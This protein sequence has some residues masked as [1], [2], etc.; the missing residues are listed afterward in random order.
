MV[1]N[2]ENR[3]FSAIS[4]ISDASSQSSRA[5][6]FICCSNSDKKYL[7]KLKTFLK[8]YRRKDTLNIWDNLSMQPGLV[9]EQEIEQALQSAKVAVLL[10]SND[11]F[12]NDT[13]IEH[14]LPQ[15]ITAGLNKNITIINVILRPC[16][17]G[18]TEL[19]QFHPANDPTRP[20]INMRPAEQEECW[21]TTAKSIRDRVAEQTGTTFERLFGQPETLTT[22]AHLFF[23]CRYMQNKN[24]RE[25]VLGRL[26]TEMIQE[27][28]A[29]RNTTQDG[30]SI[31]FKE[32]LNLVKICSS[33]P[34]GLEKLAYALYQSERASQAWKELDKY[35]CKSGKKLVTYT[36]WQELYEILKP[37]QWPDHLLRRAYR[38]SVPENWEILHD[39]DVHDKIQPILEDLTRIPF[40]NNG[41]FPILEFVLRLA[42]IAEDRQEG[43]LHDTLITWHLERCGDLGLTE[44]Q[45]KALHE[46]ASQRQQPSPLYL[47][48]M[49]D[50]IS[51]TTF[52]VR[53]WLLDEKNI[54]IQNTA[55]EIPDEPYLLEEIPDLFED[56]LERC[57]NHLLDD[58]ENLVIE[59]VLPL[60]LLSYPVDQY[61]IR[62]LTNLQSIGLNH[63]VV[64]RSL[65]RMR[66][67]KRQT[68][69]INK[70][71]LLLD[72]MKDE[73]ALSKNNS[74]TF[75]Y[76]E[77]SY[78]GQEAF[79]ALLQ[80]SSIACLVLPC[81]PST[82]SSQ[83]NGVLTA[84]LEAGVPIALW[85]RE[86]T[87][88]PEA[89]H[90]WLT[91]LV[92][93]HPLSQLPAL[94]KQQRHEAIAS[95]NK[96]QHQGHH[97]TRLWDDPNRLPQSRQLAAPSPSA[98][99][100]A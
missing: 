89:L 6:I 17:F 35:L 26:P 98:S 66:R 60:Q 73:Q 33:Y 77:E 7:K 23:A 100:G 74:A 50:E 2:L 99:R 57:E 22:S 3:E 65:E 20:L 72:C 34:D 69:W 61:A 91:Q 87:D 76:Q 97:L 8:M 67:K 44:N 64:V 85:P 79:T 15:V 43:L 59:F 71:E 83:A 41:T 10:I 28:E 62:G 93:Q 84:V 92:L 45:R 51:S 86:Q 25:Q 1:H 32:M 95:G 80:G 58:M 18:Y 88:Y 90:E 19:A 53:C 70:W 4:T 52:N 24:S 78:K 12:A 9:F 54:P 14:I 13:I 29:F 63:Q 11:F 16:D 27:I 94:V 75:V 47:I 81:V 21:T 38:E 31:D 39:H 49:L 42:A 30:D 5:D 68:R 36:R 55:I 56:L 82:T 37:V 40:Q 46:K 48:L 96:Q